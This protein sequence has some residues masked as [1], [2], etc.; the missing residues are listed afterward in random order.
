MEII[1]QKQKV[2]ISDYIEYLR[3]KGYSR[4]RLTIDENSEIVSI[5]SLEKGAIGAVVN[6]RCPCQHKIV[7]AGRTQL[8]DKAHAL[9]S[10][11]ADIDNIEIA[12]DTRIRILKE[13]VSRSITVIGTV[14]YKDLTMTEYL[15]IPPNETKL[16]EKFYRFNDNIELNGNEYLKIYVIN[17]DISIDAKSVKLSLDI[18]FW[19]EE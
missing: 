6:I 2:S 17:P 14:F 8:P 3:G 12:P 15:K 10:R 18:D 19:E 7:I 1:G 11:L 5:N 9:A 16:Y 4:E 13:K